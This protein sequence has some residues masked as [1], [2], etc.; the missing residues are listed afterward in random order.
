[1][2]AIIS[3]AKTLDFES[4]STTRKHSVPVLLNESTQLIDKLRQKAPQ[5]IADLMR[6]SSKLAELN[7]DRYAAWQPDF[8]C[9]NA[10]QAIL[11]FKGD[12]YLGLEAETYSQR[13][14]TWAQKHLRILSGL[15][16]ILKPLDLIQPY[17]LEMGTQ[18]G[19]KKGRD[20]YQFWGDKVT[21]ELNSAIADQRQALL[22]NLA[23][24]EYFNVVDAT[25]IDARI[26]TPKFLDLKNGRY[27][28][29]SFFAKK[30]RGLM[31]SYIVKHRVST[32]KALKNFDWHG[33]RYSEELSTAD[34]WTF[35]RDKP[36]T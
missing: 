15:H 11:A 23:S 19:T 18:L 14:F 36:Q 13:D 24:I 9:K 5:D 34:E 7:Y 10:K 20:L 28:F 17:R 4:P 26:I 16:G 25:K 8:S 33:Y 35:L 30:A 31:A 21:D 6:I 27:K 2:L 22:I 12:V 32:L 1:M 29:L 3:P